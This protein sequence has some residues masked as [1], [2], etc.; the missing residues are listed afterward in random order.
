[1]IDFVFLHAH[2][3]LEWIEEVTQCLWMVIGLKM[4][5]KLVQEQEKKPQLENGVIVE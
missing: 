4:M 5:P 1:M 2:G 3:Q